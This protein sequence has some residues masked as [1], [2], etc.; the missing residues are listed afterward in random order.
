MLYRAAAGRANRTSYTVQPCVH[1]S[2]LLNLS[3][4]IRSGSPPCEEEKEEE[5][6]PHSG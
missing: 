1:F 5:E 3:C 2:C 4:L 6:E